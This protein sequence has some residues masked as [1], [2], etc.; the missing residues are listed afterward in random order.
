MRG[1]IRKRGGNSW[2][3][4]YDI[5]RADGRRQTRYKSFRGSKREAQ[6]ELT[7]LL[8]QVQT[9][10]HIEP[11]KLT[12][13]EHVRNRVT[14]WHANGITSPKTHER[15][16]ELVEY[17]MARFPIAS[18]PLQKLTAAD[19]EAWH[20]AL[21]TKGRQDGTGGVS[22]R[23]IHHA[24]KLLAKALREGARHGL[25]F[26]NVATEERPPKIGIKPIRIL[27]PEQVKE[28]PTKLAGRSIC[29]PAV[30]AL[31][32]G[33]RRGELLALHWSAV[34]LDRKVIEIRDALEQT[35]AH[36]VRFKGTKTKSGERVIGLPNIVV[37]TLR[38]HRRQQL[39]LRLALGL[40]KL[41]RDALVFPSP[42]TERPWN[43][44]A[45]SAAWSDVSV[46]LGLGIG[47][48]NLRHTHASQLIAAGVPITEIAHRLGHAS[49][50]TTLSVYAHLFER[51]DSK[52]AAA[53]DAA[54]ASRVPV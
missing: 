52:A 18:R 6:A 7:R 10:S 26:K 37:D 22:N 41:S 27:T 11:H 46:E 50:T 17:Q 54:F 32:T 9:G 48:H 1:H 43:P 53:I 31:F 30:V 47:F 15:Y 51:D 25:V 38:E 16:E 24:H 3:I 12:V 20:T 40:G 36:G 8:S 21:R 19:I 29:A 2:E 14:L 28:L 35:V 42:G 5:D 23:T 45:F 39:E 49:P 33:A 4:K 13:I 44:D 34:D